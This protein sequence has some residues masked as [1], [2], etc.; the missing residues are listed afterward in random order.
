MAGVTPAGFDRKTLEEIL[1]EIELQQLADI[2]PTLDQEGDAL[3]GQLNAVMANGFGELWEVLE[4][5]YNSQYPD[6]AGDISLDN[7]SAITGTTRQG[8]TFSK[9]L[10][11]CNLDGLFTLLAGSVAFIP[12]IPGVRFLLDEDLENTTVGA[13]TFLG[14]A[15]TAETAG[16]VVANSGTVTGGP[17]L[18]TGWN[19]CTNPL[20]AEVGEEVENDAQLRLRR[21]LE[22]A[23]PGGASTDAI[24]AD[25]LKL[26]GVISASVIEN[27]DSIVSPDGIPPHAFEVVVLGGDD[28]EIAEAIFANKAAGI[29]AFG[30]TTVVVQ[31]SEENDV[32]IG[33]TRPT[34]KDIWLEIDIAVDANY[35]SNGDDLVKAALVTF[36]QQTFLQGQDV[37]AALLKGA[38]FAVLGVRDTV[39][40]RLDFTAAPVPIVNLPILVR[41]LAA[42]D[43][44]RV[45]VSTS[46]FVDV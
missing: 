6:T 32:T 3:L 11:D 26:D 19:S 16:A 34:A 15:F 23:G 33:F 5:V 41:E 46:T 17:D 36:G 35:P 12:S 40:L 9:I 43:T 28:T 18:V 44:S 24:R 14:V 4:A 7:V 22:V 25:V 39:E 10:L 21:L 2:D 45:T 13:F 27:T 8:Q 30:S 1:D 20:D 31:D 42:F 38:A 37:I 29:L